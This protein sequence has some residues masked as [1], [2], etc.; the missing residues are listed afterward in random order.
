MTTMMMKMIGCS[1]NRKR[2]RVNRGPTS[3][4]QKLKTFLAV[5]VVVVVVVVLV[6][7]K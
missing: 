2:S 7:S 5:V 4:F 3:S 6:G 1:W